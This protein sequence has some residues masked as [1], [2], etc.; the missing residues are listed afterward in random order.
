MPNLQNN[1]K[2]KSMNPLFISPLGSKQGVLVLR[3]I[4]AIDDFYNSMTLNN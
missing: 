4:N 2:Y 3:C 1:Q